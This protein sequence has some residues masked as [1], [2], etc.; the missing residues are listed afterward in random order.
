M[1]HPFLLSS[2]HDAEGSTRRTRADNPYA[3]AVDATSVHWIN[4]FGGQVRKL[5]PK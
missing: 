5:T 3:I 2:F 1:I 4:F